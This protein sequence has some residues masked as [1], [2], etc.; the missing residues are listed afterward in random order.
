MDSAGLLVDNEV[1]VF[2]SRGYW[3]VSQRG[4]TPVSLSRGYRVVD[5]FPPE[6]E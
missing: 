5:T 3:L 6:A 1:T 4:E 2:R